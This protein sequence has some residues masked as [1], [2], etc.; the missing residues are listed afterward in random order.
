M[1]TDVEGSVARVEFLVDGLVVAVDSDGPPFT[2]S[3]TNGTP[4]QY[5]FV[6]RAVDSEGANSLSPQVD[7]RIERADVAPSIR[8]F[9]PSALTVLRQNASV[10]LEAEVLNPTEGAHSVEFLSGTRPL[11][12]LTEAPFRWTWTNLH[13]GSFVLSVRLLDATNGVLAS[14]A[15]VPI[16][17]T[18]DCGEI[19][20]VRNYADPE[21]DRLRLRFL[22]AGYRSVVL[23]QSDLVFERL[24][25]HRLIV[26]EGLARPGEGLSDA[27]V[28]VFR[29]LH[30]NAT[31]LLF[32]GPLL[33]SDTSRLSPQSRTVWHSLI[34]LA[35]ST[36]SL[37]ADSVQWLRAGGNDAFTYGT[38]GGGLEDFLYG[39][40]VEQAVLD[41]TV[42]EVLARA[43]GADV[44][45]CSPPVDDAGPTDARIVAIN[46]ALTLPGMLGD[47]RM[48]ERLFDHAVCWLMVCRGCPLP[49]V[50]SQIEV[51][52]N[53][54][55]L[56]EEFTYRLRIAQNGECE[57]RGV[58]A[59]HSVPAD[60]RILGVT[61]ERGVWSVTDH[62]VRFEVG[63]MPFGDFADFAITAVADEAGPMRFST[64]LRSSNRFEPIDQEEEPLRIESDVRPPR[65]EARRE[66][67][68]RLGLRLLRRAG[69]TF[70]IRSSPDLRTWSSAGTIA[71]DDWQAF[72]IASEAQFFRIVQ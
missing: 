54:V 32:L 61:G 22:D 60:V 36:D 11:A 49:S 43:D 69:R 1:A 38:S 58:T 67:D 7:V 37:T 3:W 48:R 27:D 29:R 59:V 24:H 46:L 12:L 42:G 63:T 65:I 34:H 18:S 2:A 35:P 13:E 71:A 16:G 70:Q 30:T 72:S 10:A 39:G 25:S 66:A 41:G 52:T 17:V 44:V 5:G 68:G 28:E 64:V 50:V 40:P 19:A 20:I 26:W 23:E 15:P 53:T 45:V 31:P 8:L 56:G 47:E 51:S 6:A 62:S 55:A 33:A 4:G 14:S 9:S 21:T 57:G